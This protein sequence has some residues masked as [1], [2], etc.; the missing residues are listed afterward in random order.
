MS[1]FDKDIWNVS[2]EDGRNFTLL[3]RI[4]YTAA[5]GSVYVIPAGA[6][7]DGA[8][9]PAG[10]WPTIPPFGRYWKAAV[11]HDWLYRGSRMPKEQC[12]A[13]LLEAMA[14]LGVSKLERDLIYQGV[15]LG[16]ESSFEADRQH[17]IVIQSVTTTTATA[18]A[19]PANS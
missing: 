15:H 8:S 12:D 17:M 3:E 1:S 7:T 16:G 14:A 9:T 13:L 6:T 18:P 10:L 19:A 4:T 5:D 2:T 11:L